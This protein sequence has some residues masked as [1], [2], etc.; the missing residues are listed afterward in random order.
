MGGGGGAVCGEGGFLEGS[1]MCV[2]CVFVSRHTV[3]PVS[4]GINEYCELTMTGKCL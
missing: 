4:E 3:F 1:L 2:L